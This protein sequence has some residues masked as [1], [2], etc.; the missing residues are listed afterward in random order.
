MEWESSNMAITV[1]EGSLTASQA[2][3]TAF[4]CRNFIFLC[5]WLCK[6]FTAVHF[7][8]WCTW[9]PQLIHHISLAL[10]RTSKSSGYCRTRLSGLIRI[11][12]L[13]FV[14]VSSGV[15]EGKDAI[16]KPENGRGVVQNQ[17]KRSK[18]PC[19]CTASPP[20]LPAKEKDYYTT[21]PKSLS[22]VIR[23]YP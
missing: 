7:S 19:T 17:C 1:Y 18:N 8:S 4:S 12:L 11:P 22:V 20:Q 5:V 16:T 3:N 23:S 9:T 21:Q 6:C 2:R 10:L 15:S 14:S 13:V